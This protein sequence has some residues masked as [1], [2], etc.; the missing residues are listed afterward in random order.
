MTTIDFFVLCLRSK[1]S[2]IRNT[3]GLA[4]IIFRMRIWRQTWTLIWSSHYPPVD[5]NIDFGLRKIWKIPNSCLFWRQMSLWMRTSVETQSLFWVELST[6]LEL[7]NLFWQ[8]STA[9]NLINPSELDSKLHGFYVLTQTQIWTI[10]D[11]QNVPD[12]KFTSL[13]D[14]L[15]HCNYTYS[16]CHCEDNLPTTT[17]RCG[18]VS[19]CVVDQEHKG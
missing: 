6:W 14:I 12:Q 11:C 8:P 16:P 5:T 3:A 1:T 2:L 10:K 4:W 9:P 7:V 15:S 18:D 13:S 19:K 17:E